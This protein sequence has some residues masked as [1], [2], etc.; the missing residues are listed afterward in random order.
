[1]ELL[2]GSMEVCFIFRFDHI[3][4]E[5][6]SWDEGEQTHHDNYSFLCCLL[7]IYDY[8]INLERSAGISTILREP[9]LIKTNHRS[10]GDQADLYD[11][12]Y[13]NT[14]DPMS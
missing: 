10:E 12:Q 8:H 11:L 4:N 5:G 14:K 6:K 2:T 1:M 9:E 7:S 13:T 3:E